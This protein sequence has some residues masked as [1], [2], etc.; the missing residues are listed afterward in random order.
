MSFL[1]RIAKLFGEQEKQELTIDDA[2]KIIS[3]Q[4][5][6]KTSSVMDESY[7]NTLKI[8]SEIQSLQSLISNFQK[9][10]VYDEKAKAS[11]AVKDRFCQSS[12]KQ[13]SAIEKPEKDLENIRRFLDEVTKIEKLGGMTP[14]QMMHV[15]FFFKEEL[16][17]ISR[18][19]IV[20]G[21]LVKN[22]KK[23]LDSL[24]EYEK[25]FST[26]EKIKSLEEEL[27]E[28][29]KEK[30]S[31]ENAI[32]NLKSELMDIEKK[33]NEVDVI[34][35]NEAEKVLMAAEADKGQVEQ[36]LISYLSLDKM[37]KKL[38]HDKK[39]K[40]SI[41]DAYI[42][43]AIA[44]LIDD[45]Q[46]KIFRFIEQVKPVDDKGRQKLERILENQ[47][48][49]KEKRK[50]LIELSE[51]VQ[52]K[53]RKL[54]DVK[55]AIEEKKTILTQQNNRIDIQLNDYRRELEKVIANIQDINQEID[56][57]K[58]ELKIMAEHLTNSEIK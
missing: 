41:L 16:S 6:A 50:E 49:I 40:D 23:D 3:D 20:I 38:R 13:L 52:L 54:K 2:I 39:I 8:Y 14:R 30:K 4:R 53:K 22:V 9:A 18:K 11:N 44:A 47:D 29:D 55:D 7:N 26:I 12:E 15:G 42:N 17:R 33:L 46:M 37:L 34:Q 56:N 5:N 32:E 19:T 48:Y 43:S 36:D 28:K 58:I 1:D 45:H 24:D 57:G 35:L 21:D 51:S 27:P 10:Q 31:M 25:F